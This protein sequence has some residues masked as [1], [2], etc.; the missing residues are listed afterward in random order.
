LT[1]PKALQAALARS[2]A[3]LEAKLAGPTSGASLASDLKALMLTLNR[4]LQESGARA[5]AARSDIG[6]H[7]PLPTQH[8]PLAALSTAPAT[9]SLLDVPAQQMN[10]LSR[11]TEGALARLT[12]VQIANAAPDPSH[13]ILI[14]LP[15]RHHDRASVLRLRIEQDEARKHE[16]GSDTAWAVEAALELGAVGSLHARITL[17]GQRIG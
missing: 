9:L 2:G 4:A 13:A 16:G 10:E 14:E 3:F 8:G 17:R 7:A 5:S 1:D 11:Q 6:G 12:T 15:I